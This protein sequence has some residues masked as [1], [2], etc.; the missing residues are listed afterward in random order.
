MSIYSIQQHTLFRALG[1]QAAVLSYPQGSD[2]R[3][4]VQAER[5]TA[6]ITRFASN[7]AEVDVT[8]TEEDLLVLAAE[9][10]GRGAALLEAHRARQE[11]IAASA[12]STLSEELS[13]IAKTESED[14]EQ[15]IARDIRLLRIMEEIGRLTATPP[16]QASPK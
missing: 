3:L 1:A 9:A 6:F 15:P 4:A 8:D 11:A 2:A 7:P 5:A 14:R 16:P 13:A 12:L 10:L